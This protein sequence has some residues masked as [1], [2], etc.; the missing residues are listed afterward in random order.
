MQQIHI[1][2]GELE[3]KKKKEKKKEKRGNILLFWDIAGNGIFS[4]QFL[5][6]GNNQKKKKIMIGIK[7]N[8]TTNCI[9]FFFLHFYLKPKTSQTRTP[10]PPPCTEL[11]YSQSYTIVN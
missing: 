1:F 10:L 6:F 3:K 11:N 8:S 4:I 9:F 7:K 2:I 5:D